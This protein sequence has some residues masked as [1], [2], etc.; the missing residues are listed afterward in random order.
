MF[1]IVVT[2]LLICFLSSWI[3]ANDTKLEV[4]PAPNGI[5]KSHNFIVDVSQNGVAQRSFVYYSTPLDNDADN[6]KD[7]QN[8][9][10]RG[11]NSNP[12]LSEFYADGKKLPMDTEQS[13]S[14]TCFSFSG[15]VQVKI[16]GK[17]SISSFKILPSSAGIVG[18]VEE[19][20]LTF[21]LEQPQK[22][23]IVLNGDYLN[24]LFLFADASE[25]GVPDK[26]AEGTLVIREGDDCE[27]LKQDA[28]DAS[29]VWF[30]PGV[31]DIGVA[32]QVYEGQ[33]IYL[34]GGSYLL[35]TLHGYM[36]P[37]VTI[38]GRG[39]LAGDAISRK[40]VLALKRETGFTKRIVE[41][42]RYHG[43]NMLCAQNDS[44]WNAFADY[45]GMGCD[46]LVIEGITIA[47]PRQF[48]IRATGVPMTIYNV[49]MVGS[50]PYNTDGFSGIG[51]ANTTVF[52]CFFHCNDDAIY[53]TPD[54][55]HIHHCNFWQGNNGCVFQFAWG[56]AP[57]TQGGG[58]IHDCNILHLGHVEEANNRMV[59]G[60]RKRG[61]GDIENIHFKNINI[62]GPVWSLIRLETNGGGELGSFRNITF[63][64]IYVTG[65]VLHKSTVISSKGKS[66]DES[67]T[68]WIENI[69]LK[70][71]KINDQNITADDIV[72]GD[73]QVENISVK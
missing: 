39:I 4:Y 27:A 68:S 34:E 40:S 13:C 66:D 60:S 20:A 53:V 21:S 31:H 38:K 63:E 67:S 49:K 43:I 37:N 5:M 19:G 2:I 54:N 7:I 48:F 30:E 70:N 25:V 61:L 6:A 8:Q 73:F 65:L 58:F 50:W 47:N 26:D 15:K 42:M 23:G 62:E 71:I 55:C 28:K 46:N 1:K 17:E 59:F 29:V 51:Q 41:R 11:I 22:L 69:T 12:V 16:T 18:E 32:F 9:V 14:Y 33:T 44:S 35:G 52:D 64:N 3:W 72:I 56:S 24:P 57:K 45:P 10:V 36:A